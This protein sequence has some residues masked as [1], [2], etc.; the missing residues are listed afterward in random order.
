MNSTLY[1]KEMTIDFPELVAAGKVEEAFG[2]HISQDF[3][4]HNP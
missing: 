4:R 2:N 1:F 3:C